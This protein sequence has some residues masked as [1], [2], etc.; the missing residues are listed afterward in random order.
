MGGTYRV[1]EQSRGSRL[2]TLQG[3]PGCGWSWTRE[4]WRGSGGPRSAQL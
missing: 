1:P 4:V 3:K 2:L